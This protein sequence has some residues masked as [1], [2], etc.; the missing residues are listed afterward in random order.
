MMIDEQMHVDWEMRELKI[1]KIQAFGNEHI[2][3]RSSS[4]VSWSAPLPDSLIVSVGWDPSAPNGQRPTSEHTLPAL[5]TIAPQ[6]L[7]YVKDVAIQEHA[8]LGRSKLLYLTHWNYN[9]VTK[10]GKSRT[11]YVRK[12]LNKNC[13]AVNLTI[14][15]YH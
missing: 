9:Q 5:L 2:V 8:L 11:F 15:I 12:Q 7:N 3:C 4:V 1:Y 6:G 13:I 14:K 10:E